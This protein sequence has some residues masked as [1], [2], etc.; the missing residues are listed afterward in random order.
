MLETEDGA[1]DRRGDCKELSA[2][3]GAFTGGGRRRRGARED[4]PMG[5]NSRG[6]NR[7]EARERSRNQ[8][9]AD[10]STRVRLSCGLGRGEPSCQRCLSI[11]SIQ[12][13]IATCD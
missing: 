3:R 11:R 9:L 4:A 1:E 8:P 7:P 12:L 6:Q 10:K 13:A 5:G 2:C